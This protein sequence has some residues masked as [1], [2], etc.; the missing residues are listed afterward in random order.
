MTSKKVSLFC[1]K[2]E[3]ISS[4]NAVVEGVPVSF[5]TQPFSLKLVPAGK[6]GGEIFDGRERA[7]ENS[8]SPATFVRAR[9]ALGTEDTHAAGKDRTHLQPG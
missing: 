4:A 3:K 6:G 7:Q 9:H 5:S 8:V 1:N 2:G